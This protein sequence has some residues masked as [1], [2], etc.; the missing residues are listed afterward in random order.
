[1]KEVGLF[2]QH[3]KTLG[4]CTSVADCPCVGICSCTQWGDDRCRGCGRTATEVRDW[5]TFSKIEKKIINLRNAAEN[6]GIRQLKRGKG[7]QAP[8]KAVS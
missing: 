8:Q 1:M 7:V 6:Y 2:T 3:S 4:R 5:N